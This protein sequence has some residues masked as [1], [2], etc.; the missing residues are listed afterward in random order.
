M[1]LNTFSFPCMKLH[2]MKSCMNHFSP[3]PLSFH[4]HPAGF[5][6]LIL[7]YVLSISF[8]PSPA[9]GLPNDLQQA[10]TAAAGIQPYGIGT[11]FFF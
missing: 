3:A 9:P 4:S 10:Y 1:R 11:I 7:E 6:E 2:S 8:F 5:N